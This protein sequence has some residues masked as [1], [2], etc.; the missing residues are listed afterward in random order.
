[1]ITT[2]PVNNNDGPSTSLIHSKNET[3]SIVIPV[4][5][6]E[7]SVPILYE[8][9]KYVLLSINRRYEI[10][11]VDDGS[12]DNTF[13]NILTL[14]EKDCCVK[15]IKFR[16]NFGKAEALSAAFKY[17]KGS[18]IITMDGDLQ[19]DPLEIPKFIDKIEDGYDLVSGWKYTRHDPITKRLPSIFF[20]K[21]TCILTG[22][23]LH[24]FNCGFKAYRKEVT[25]NINLYGEMHRYI[26]ALAA[27]YGFKITEITVKHHPRKYGKSKYGFKRIIKGFLDLITVK[28]LISY[29]SRPLHVFGVPGIMSSTI[30]FLIGVHLLILKYTKNILLSERPLL[31]LAVLLMLIGFQFI[32]IGLLGEMLTFRQSKD[33]N[34]SIYIEKIIEGTNG[35]ESN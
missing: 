23:E 15:I 26:P 17:A 30:G 29:S 5:N 32:S 27:W 25:D 19:D 20:N 2:I 24:D 16:K 12:I 33:E 34:T 9:L 7:K 22:V 1:M 28:F 8:Q 21:L 13:Q 3:L 35:I 10:I 11:F 14:S 18:I 4:K 6:E 31:L